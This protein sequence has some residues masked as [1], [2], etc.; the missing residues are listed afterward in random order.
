MLRIAPAAPACGR[1]FM[2]AP[3]SHHNEG[4]P[5]MITR[6]ILAAILK[7]VTGFFA[8]LLGAIRHAFAPAR[9]AFA[10]PFGPAS[11]AMGEPRLVPPASMGWAVRAGLAAVAGRVPP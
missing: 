4:V 1:F 5:A 3:K 9:V 2:P 8:P 7:C 6:A 10:A 11:I